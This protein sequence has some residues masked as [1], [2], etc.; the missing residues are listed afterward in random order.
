MPAPTISGELGLTTGTNPLSVSL[1]WSGATVTGTVENYEVLLLKPPITRLTS[2]ELS[3]WATVVSSDT[4]TLTFTDDSHDGALSVN[5]LYFGMVRPV[6]SDGKSQEWL[7]KS[8][9]TPHT[10]PAWPANPGPKITVLNSDGFTV[11]WKAAT[12]NPEQYR[13]AVYQKSPFRLVKHAI[14]DPPLLSVDIDGLEEKTDYH[15][16]VVATNDGGASRHIQIDTRTEADPTV[17]PVM[18][19]GITLK[20]GF[21]K[22]N[23]AWSAAT[24][25]V[26]K[27][28]VQSTPVKNPP[29]PVGERWGSYDYVEVDGTDESDNPV[30]DV[31]ITRLKGDTAYWFRVRAY[32]GPADARNYSGYVPSDAG[33]S[34]TADSEE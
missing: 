24:G 6:N 2:D 17:A 4:R 8:I 31:D 9:T 10:K 15:V 1:D 21:E 30:T 29:L 22:V 27:Y 13:V 7:I 3:G 18:S 11:S 5:T 33:E 19:G 14:V 20:P 25:V 16:I 34:A 26:W 12:R 23:V 32:N 28:E